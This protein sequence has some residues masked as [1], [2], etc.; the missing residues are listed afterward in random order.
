ML[1]GCGSVVFATETVE[2]GGFVSTATT[3][4][5]TFGLA[6]MVMV[7]AVGRVSGAHFNPAVSVGAAIGGRMAWNQVPVYVAAQLVGAILGA[8]VLF[9]LLHG[10]EG[11]DAEGNMGQNGFG[12]ESAATTRCGRRCCSSWC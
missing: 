3:I 4:G 1:F 7:Y 9:G 5:L 8:A 10:F 11:F 12:D 2:S 6:L